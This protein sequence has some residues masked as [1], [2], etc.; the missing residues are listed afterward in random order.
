M[1][2]VIDCTTDSA[3]CAFDDDLEELD[4]G[5][6]ALSV[7]VTLLS[8]D[9]A[10][11]GPEAIA[12]LSSL[13]GR[14]MTDEQRLTVVEL[15][16]PQLAWA[17]GAEQA[18]IVALVGP[19]PVTN[20]ERDSDFSGFELSA[21]LSC[22][23]DHAE[24]RIWRARLLAGRFVATGDLLRAGE[25]DPY[26]VHVLLE[27]LT[28]LHPEQAAQV[29]AE[30]LPLAAGMT[31]ARLRRALRKAARRVDP[32]WDARMFAQKNKTRRVGFN[33]DAESGMTV[34]Y[35]Y[36][37]P[38]DAAAVE[39]HLKQAAAVPSPDPD[40]ARCH[41]ERMADALVA[42]VLGSAAGDPT[43]PL[44]PK[45]LVQVLM[46]LPTLLGLREDTGELR[47]YGDIPADVARELA[48][49]ADFQR[50]IHDP[51]DGHL[52]DQGDR[53]YRPRARLRRFVQAR[54]RFC[55]FPGSGRSAARSDLD[56]IE[57][58]QPGQ[59]GSTSAANLAALSRSVHRAKTHGG[60]DLVRN[61]DGTLT[62]TTPLGRQHTV[63]PH[64]Y[65][66]DSER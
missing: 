18:A 46:S 61:D 17:A 6:P 3:F 49:D 41:D 36:L 34:M 15:W 19:E 32:E 11:P 20:A 29:E 43:T 33:P 50:W 14:Q 58:F 30:L 55:Q 26:R 37:A 62:W 2:Q 13:A 38:A 45:V 22:T 56:H 57:E 5:R 64:D 1:D 21:A 66:P 8:V 51:V 27:T 16:Q 12:L 60:Y 24:Q 10:G 53:D 35:A 28:T 65:R 54:D 4:L 44:A 23:T 25:L 40:D 63:A 47:G 52:L 48:G 39:E 59:G 7:A 31:G 9:L 42:C